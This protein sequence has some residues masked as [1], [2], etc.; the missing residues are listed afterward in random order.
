[1][2]QNIGTCYVQSRTNVLAELRDEISLFLF[3]N[4]MAT[5]TQITQHMNQRCS[6]KRIKAEDLLKF[7]RKDF[8]QGKRLITNPN[9]T[10]AVHK[11]QTLYCKDYERIIAA[12]QPT[13]KKLSKA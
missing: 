5:N 9:E 6:F 12:F 3:H 11:V 10:N 1:M 8:V 13:S 4:P 2:C 7:I